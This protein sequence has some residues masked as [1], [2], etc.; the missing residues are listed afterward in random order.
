MRAEIY[1]REEPSPDA[2]Q[3]QLQ[4]VLESKVFAIAPRLSKFLRF[5]VE[6][7]LAGTNPVNEYSI[8]VDVFER[9]NS[10]DP[11]VDPIVR[12]HARRLRSK[13][14]QYYETVGLEDRIEIQ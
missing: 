7:A 11:R 10:F 4:R 2:V 13:L 8:G 12:V 6:S 14:A 9:D 5:G 1:D 3:R